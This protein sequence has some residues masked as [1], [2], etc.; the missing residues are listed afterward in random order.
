[1]PNPGGIIYAMGAVGTTLVK[2]G[3]PKTSVE[4]RR[5][6]LQTGQPF[7]LE[8]LATIAVEEDLGRIEKQVHAF[9]EAERR[10]GEW[11]DVAMDSTHLEALVVR[12]VQYIAEQEEIT[13]LRQQAQEAAMHTVGDVLPNLATIGERV[14]TARE[15][16]GIHQAELARRLGCSV[17]ALS[18]LENN[19]ITDPR[20]S[21]IIGIAETLG[22]SADFLLGLQDTA[23]DP[24]STRTQEDAHAE[25]PPA[26][27]PR[28]R[29]AVPV[30]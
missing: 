8:V 9:L 27:R 11:F 19:A 10:R 13:R 28:T 5:Q 7:A 1:M 29:T 12:A 15:Q 18:M 30:S 22:V 17:N 2:I 23:A 4:Q 24:N 3:S 14:K 26:K 6:R 21:R 16:C 20:A 25:Q